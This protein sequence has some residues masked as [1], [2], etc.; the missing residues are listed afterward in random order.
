MK[1]YYREY[2]FCGNC[3]F[4]FVPN[5]FHIS[6]ELELER[7]NLHNWDLIQTEE[8]EVNSGEMNKNNRWDN[9][10][11]FFDN[12]SK[13]IIDLI[14]SENKDNDLNEFKSLDFGCGKYPNFSKIFEFNF[15]KS[16]LNQNRIKTSNYDNYYSKNEKLLLN[17]GYDLIT[18]FEVLEHLRNPLNE[19]TIIKDLLEDNGVL[20]I[21]TQ[22][23]DNIT[24][25]F[26]GLF[27][28]ELLANNFGNWWYKNDITHINF[29]SRKTFEILAVKLNLKLI[30][31]EE[32]KMNNNLLINNI[33]FFKNTL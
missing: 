8:I 3:F 30:M 27:D 2:N 20:V 14:H 31:V 12:I 7:Y 18:S 23:L 29:Y 22:L 16:K 13:I 26:T 33:I 4:I 28:F 9:R 6:N 32:N 15:N 10:N 17:T 19:L 11:Q 1:S 21:E 25:D 5:E 24:N